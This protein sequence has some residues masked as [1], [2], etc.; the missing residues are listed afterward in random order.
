MIEPVPNVPDV[1]EPT[2]PPLPVT[3]QIGVDQTSDGLPVVTLSCSVGGVIAAMRLAPDLAL[4]VARHL[5]DAVQRIVLCSGPP[6]G[7]A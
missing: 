7:S 1:P 3:M 5:D 2:I 6:Q 4:L